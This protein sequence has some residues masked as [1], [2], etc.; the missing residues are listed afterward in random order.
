MLENK[1][2]PAKTLQPTPRMARVAALL[3]EGTPAGEAMERAGYAQSYAHNP[4][5]LM[6]RRRMVTAL[7]RLAPEMT[8]ELIEG[9]TVRA[10]TGK[11]IG[12][13]LTG[14]TLAAR[15]RGLLIERRESLNLNASSPSD[16]AAMR[17]ELTALYDGAPPTPGHDAT[18]T[19]QTSRAAKS[20]VSN[21][22]PGTVPHDDT[23]EC[24]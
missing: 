12:I 13:A 1:A 15:L 5:Q 3:M 9:T 16:I 19:P 2:L 22:L 18:L 14:A 20:S 10:M 4:H 17:A 8:A 21:D 6:R 23:G 11:D 24:G 7:K